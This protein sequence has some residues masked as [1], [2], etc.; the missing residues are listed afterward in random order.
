MTRRGLV[1]CAAVVVMFGVGC[2]S[3]T[4]TETLPLQESA[5]VVDEDVRESSTQVTE[6]ALTEDQLREF[7]AGCDDAEGVPLEVGHS[8]RTLM[9]GPPVGC[10]RFGI[11][12]RIYDVEAVGSPLAG[13][14][15]I[16]DGRQGGSLCDEASRSVC[17]RVGLTDEALASVARPSPTPSPTTTDASPTESSPTT[18]TS[19]PT[20]SDSSS[21]STESPTESTAP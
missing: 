10:S 3:A 4:E 9:E 1:V 11:C 14:A 15:E 12:L 16:V 21:G 18:A 8:C 19:D 17:M 5:L 20:S 2:V 6:Y 13:Y 7:E